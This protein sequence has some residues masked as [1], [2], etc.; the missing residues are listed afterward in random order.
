MLVEDDK[1]LC[2]SCDN[3]GLAYLGQRL[4]SGSVR[5]HG[6]QIVGRLS[7]A[8][9]QR[10]HGYGLPCCRIRGLFPWQGGRCQALYTI[11]TASCTPAK[12]ARSCRNFISVLRGWMFTSRRVGDRVIPSAA[13]GWRPGGRSAPY[14]LSS[15][16]LT[17]GLRTG[18]P[19]T[20]QYCRCR[21]ARSID[22]GLTAPW[23]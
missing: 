13:T 6:A 14:A 20:Q 8:N 11:S 16:A 12:M 7:L 4:H 15:A 21:V 3:E 5:S 19:F 23:M 9:V 1:P 22:G 10:W 2:A 18:R 17:R